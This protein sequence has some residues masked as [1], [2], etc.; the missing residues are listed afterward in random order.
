[1][2]MY[3]FIVVGGGITGLYAT[4]KLRQ[5]YGQSKILLI[6]ERSYMG[7]RLITNKSP[8]YEIGG[9]RFF[10]HHK[11]L[12]KLIDQFKLSK[13]K[14][15]SDSQYIELH[16]SNVKYFR[17][18]S[19]T[20]DYIMK[21]IIQESKQYD[22][23]TLM[24]FTLHE[25][26]CHI[27]GSEKLANDMRCVFGYDSEFTKMNCVDSLR[28][29][30]EEFT[31]PN[32]YVLKEGFSELCEKMSQH[33]KK[34]KNTQIMKNTKI[35]KIHETNGHYQLVS[36]DNNTYMCKNLVI[37]IKSAQLKK[38]KI[39]KHIFKHIDNI[40]G[41]P[42][43]RIYAQYPLQCGKSWFENIPKTRTNSCLRQIIPINPKTGLIMISYTDGDDIVPFCKNSSLPYKLKTDKEIKH[44]IK[45]ELY[46]LF[47]HINIP[48][49]HYFKCH[50]W[51]VGVHHWKPGCDSIEEYKKIMNPLK[52][53]Y[54]VGEAFSQRQAWIEGGLETVETMMRQI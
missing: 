12:M 4:Q 42:L 43:L 5:K 46:R 47:P 25:F 21:K 32:F 51:H 45:N 3:D 17:E 10:E 40:H 18:S 22:K 49:P 26:I 35:V 54:I 48:E 33:N 34:N 24:R 7:G 31:D 13:I 19:L 29:F 44:L 52:N 27:S 36:S 39:L 16:H 9:A 2:N 53:V 30:S 8:Q 11:I 6:D 15:E 23:Q 14:V 28:S 41:A 1:M 38:F 37:A 20:F 50:I